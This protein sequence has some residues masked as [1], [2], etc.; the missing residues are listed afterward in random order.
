MSK[1]TPGPW[2][3]D[4]D[5]DTGCIVSDDGVVTC[6]SPRNRAANASLIASA[7]D[8]LAELERLL[9]VVGEED[10]GFIEAVIRRAKGE[11]A[12]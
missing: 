6:V 2:R 11:V 12:E 9:D 4:E 7:P 1:H 10:V 5:G 3:V 8:M